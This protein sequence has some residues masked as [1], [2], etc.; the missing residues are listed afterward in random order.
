MTSLV[1]LVNLLIMMVLIDLKCFDSKFLSRTLI[2]YV[3]ICSSSSSSFL[4]CWLNLYLSKF[5]CLW[6]KH[7]PFVTDLYCWPYK[8][9]PTCCLYWVSLVIEFMLFGNMRLLV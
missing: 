4:S 3:R 8:V 1:C 6:N 7:R 9:R 5:C 2:N